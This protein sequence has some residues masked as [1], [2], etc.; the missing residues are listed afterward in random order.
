M[1]R[2]MLASLAVMLG[3]AL[4][5][6]RAGAVEIE[7]WQYIFPTRVTAMDQLIQ[8]FQAANPGITV[9]HTQ[10]PYADY[11]AKV[12]AAVPAGEGP[13]VVQLFYG[14]LDHFIQA[15]LIQPLPKDAFPA[16]AIEADFPPMVAAMKRGDDY[17]GLPTAVRS[18]AL[19]WNKTLFQRAGLDPEKPPQTLDELVEMAGKLTV[20]DG[21]GNYTQLGLATDVSG[22]D[23]PWWREV[24]VRQFG[25]EPYAD[26]YRRVTYADAAGAQA[27]Q[28]YVDLQLKDHV[29]QAGFLENNQ[30][31]FKAGR[32]AMTIDGS[33]SVGQFSATRGLHFGVAELPAGPTGA[34]SNYASYWVNAITTKATGEK[35]EAAKKF[36]AFITSPAAMQLWLKVVGE[37]PARRSVAADRANASDPI[38][39]PFIRGLAYAHATRFAD[40][41]AQRQVGIDMVNRVLLQGQPAA[42]SVAAAAKAEQQIIDRYR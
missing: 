25:G 26:D 31:A 12:T 15:K 8:Q 32:A 37:L 41:A 34:R 30:A 24:L 19:F 27:L 9:K 2:T 10:F 36:M 29:T 5:P 39:G 40:E 11:Q 23:L 7:Y 17:Y 42:E 13:D 4:L 35:L 6:A 18:L 3:A 20:R 38:Y 22:Q 16:S 14:W 28:W 33:F 1:L 21:S